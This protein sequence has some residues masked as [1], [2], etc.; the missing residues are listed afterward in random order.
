MHDPREPHLAALK[1]IICYI[2]GTLHLGL[3]LLPSSSSDLVIYTDV[4][5]D[6]CLDTCKSTLD[7][8]VFLGDNLISWSSKHHNIV[9][10]SSVETEFRTV[11]NG[12]IE[13]T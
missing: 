7:Y 9:S 1:Q 8:V 5:W 3:L 2:C 11:A 4:D 10:R 6:R 12:V 13:A